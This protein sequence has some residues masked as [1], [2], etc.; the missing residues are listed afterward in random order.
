M[1]V[2]LFVLFSIKLNSQNLFLINI[3]TSVFYKNNDRLSDL[4]VIIKPDNELFSFNELLI[5]NVNENDIKHIE[6]GEEEEGFESIFDLIEPS[7]VN[8]GG[9]GNLTIIRK[10]TGEKVNI[11]YRNKDGSY[12]Y[13]EIDKASYI[14]RCSLTGSKRKVPIKLLELLDVIEDK[15]N[16]RPI[17]LLSGYRTKPL[18]DI[19]PGAAKKSMHLIGWAS[20]IK[21][22][23]VSSRRIRDFARK[24]KVGGVGYYPRYGFVHIDIGKLRYWEKYQYSRKKHYSGNKNRRKIVKDTKKITIS[25]LKDNKKNKNH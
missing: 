16:N 18:N 14:M 17:I 21:I 11:K 3:S 2:F 12:N 1:F 9:N 13:D 15:F 25:Q 7:P 4:N 20:D 22:D 19:T 5:N 23:G 24:L 6:E 8:L 10:D